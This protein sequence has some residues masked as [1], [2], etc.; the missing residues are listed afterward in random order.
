MPGAVSEQGSGGAVVV[1]TWPAVVVV[2]VGTAIDVLDD[3]VLLEVVD[4]VDGFEVVEVVDVV[5]GVDVVVAWV[6]EV[7]DVV[8]AGV[9]VEVDVVGTAV[10]VVEEV[11]VVVGVLAI[12]DV[13]V[14]MVVVVVV[15]GQL[16]PQ[17]GRV[18]SWTMVAAG[19]IT[20][21]PRIVGGVVRQTRSFAAVAVS[22]PAIVMP[23]ETR[24][25][26]VA[27]GAAPGPVQMSCPVL[28]TLSWQVSISMVPATAIGSFSGSIVAVV[29]IFPLTVVLP[30]ACTWREL[31]N[32]SLVM[33]ISLARTVS[34]PLAK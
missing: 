17:H 29:W 16:T 25:R 19:V 8:G 32:S 11:L 24:R 18:G 30:P 13:V 2:E 9:V 21:V 23:V 10:T 31:P 26:L 14:V 1:E 3:G 33:S 6:V 34:P 27:T 22:V 20:A 28:V 5:G 12:V 4:V 7:V 15:V